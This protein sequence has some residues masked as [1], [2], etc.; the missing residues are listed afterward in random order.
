MPLI[1]RRLRPAAEIYSSS[2]SSG[3][4][5]SIQSF[6]SSL[7][8]Y[9]A[10]QNN[11]SKSPRRLTLA[12]MGIDREDISDFVWKW[13]CKLAPKAEKPGRSIEEIEKGLEN[14]KLKE[15][16]KDPTFGSDVVIKTFYEGKNSDAHHFDWVDYPPKQISKSVAKAQDRVAIK[17][18]K[19]K[20]RS[21]TCI[22]GRYPL[23]Y[24]ML[25]VQNPTLVAALEPIL[26][27][28]NVHLDVNA[29]AVFNYPFRDLYFCYEDIIAAYKK[30]LDSEPLK[31]FLQ[32]LIQTLDDMF[33]E[34]R[35][36]QRQ[37]LN[38]GLVNFQT[39]W[40]YF[41]RDTIVYSYGNNSEL[42]CKVETTS[43][44]KVMCMDVFNI[45]VKI[46][47]FNG[48]GF[49][50]L[51]KELEI[52]AFEGNK[53]ITELL[54][55]PVDFHPE[56]DDVR[57][58]LISRGK[59]VLDLQGLSY[60]TY[61]GIGLHRD[62]G[63]M[64]KHNVESRILIDVIGYNKYHLAKGKRED[65]DLNSQKNNITKPSKESKDTKAGTKETKQDKDTNKRLS[66]EAQLEI[67]RE[68][69]EKE[70]ELMFMSPV[71]EGYA[72]KNKLWC[73]SHFFLF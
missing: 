46:M 48:K 43:Y 28:E 52:P 50:W 19:V 71:I 15:N 30:T 11:K 37:L 21:K 10:N 72:L 59:K 56:R 20:D 67:K 35:V 57:M 69:L 32:L 27:R 34:L 29:P 23:K 47:A 70:D 9:V 6:P 64:Q 24:H 4:E 54:H 38:A 26:K 18:Y 68:M 42:L 41:P 66:E 60:R 16:A 62:Q 17:V 12:K 5:E 22:D 3:S 73:K 8:R 65:K 13:R 31:A 53:P 1:A 7:Q 58:R 44:T 14:E 61:N 2:S 51:Q 36:K 40:T 55:Y 33:A 63:Q 45:H 39:A 25:E 49:V